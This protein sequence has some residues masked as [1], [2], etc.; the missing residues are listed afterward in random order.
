MWN[1]RFP[2]PIY[3][4]N[5]VTKSTI[6]QVSNVVEISG[7]RYLYVV[8]CEIVPFTLMHVEVLLLGISACRFCGL[9]FFLP[10]CIWHETVQFFPWGRFMRCRSA[11]ATFI[12]ISNMTATSGVD[13]NMND[14][15]VPRK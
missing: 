2:V 1:G 8:P 14:P 9:F 10:R 6:V 3:A 4:C 11:V 7:C 15:T 5:N 13:H 12:T